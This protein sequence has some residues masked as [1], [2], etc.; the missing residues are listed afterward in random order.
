[1][2]KYFGAMIVFVCFSFSSQTM[3]RLEI[4]NIP[5]E[6]GLFDS[7]DLLEITLKG[8]IRELLNDRAD[9][10]NYHPITFL[11]KKSDGSEISMPV[12]MKTRGHFR[13]LKENCTHPPLLIKF[14]KSEAHTSS[15]FSKQSKLKLV[16]PC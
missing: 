7:D 9:K 3:I 12:E 6:K 11:Y 5:A 8:K 16:M 10:S 13:K 14:L 4:I 1:M 15:I 2:K